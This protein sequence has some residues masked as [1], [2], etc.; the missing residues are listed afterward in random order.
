MLS[1][2]K[3]LTGPESQMEGSLWY[4]GMNDVK[5]DFGI[6]FFFFFNNVTLHTS[7]G[8]I[9]IRDNIYDT[10]WLTEYMKQ[11]MGSITSTTP[12]GGVDSVLCLVDCYCHMHMMHICA[13]LPRNL[14][15]IPPSR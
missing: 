7:R 9:S 12:L 6:F 14:I 10:L 11:S 3:G 5:Y 2:K 1:V 15:Y 13:I 8:G 4:K